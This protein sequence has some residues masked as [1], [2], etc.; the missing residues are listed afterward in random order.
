MQRTELREETWA[1][2]LCRGVFDGVHLRWNRPTRDCVEHSELA[3]LDTCLTAGIVQNLSA[4]AN[5]RCLQHDLAAPRRFPDECECRRT[6]LEPL[7][8]DR[9]VLCQRASLASCAERHVL[10]LCGQ[11]RR[12]FTGRQNRQFE[13]L[14]HGTRGLSG[15]N[16]ARSGIGWADV[17][18]KCRGGSQSPQSKKLPINVCTRRTLGLPQPAHFGAVTFSPLQKGAAVPKTAAR[19][20]HWKRSPD[21][22]LG[23][24][25]ATISFC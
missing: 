22:P 23:A 20:T 12:K 21:L 14:A 25:R 2:A 9:G 3:A 6:F 15:G 1:T 17:A 5:E 7:C 8:G 19:T 10:S 24:T 11:P 16:L 13:R 18:T 4:D